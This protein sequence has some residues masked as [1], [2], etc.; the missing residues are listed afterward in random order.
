MG[1]SRG[2]RML[3]VS[4]TLPLPELHRLERYTQNKNRAQ[5]YQWIKKVFNTRAAT[6]A[7]EQTLDELETY[8]KAQEIT[9]RQAGNHL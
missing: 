6:P 8:L 2:K 4:P 1:S 3:Q 9:I 7:M 5:R